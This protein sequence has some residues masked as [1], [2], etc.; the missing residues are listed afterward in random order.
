MAKVRLICLLDGR[1]VP[2]TSIPE[3]ERWL[4]RNR[5]ALASVRRGLKQLA[6]GN[7]H[8]LGSFAKYADDEID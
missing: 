3:E 4:F 2:E 1:R 7:V 8:N 5:E 6:Q